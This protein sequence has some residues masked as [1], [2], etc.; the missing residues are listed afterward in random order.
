MP[1]LFVVFQTFYVTEILPEQTASSI[2][3]IG[4]VQLFLITMTCLFVGLLIDRGY[5]KR[6]TAAGTCL[7]VMGLLATSFSAKYW[8]LFLAQGVCVGLGSGALGLLPVAV[9][10]M[11]FEEERM[12][13][14]GITATGTSFGE[15]NHFGTLHDA[16]YY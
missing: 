16:D 12:L 10:A 15:W 14:T 6:L 2:A 5:L 3:W 11:Y 7:E 9:I 8:Q 4:S 13:A 1:N